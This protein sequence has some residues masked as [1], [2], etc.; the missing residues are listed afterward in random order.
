[1]HVCWNRRRVA[2]GSRRRGLGTGTGPD[3][4]LGRAE[5]RQ[6][7]GGRQR[8]AD[9]RGRRRGAGAGLGRRAA[10]GRARHPRPR[11]RRLHARLQCRGRPLQPRGGQARAQQP[12]G[13]ARGRPADADGRPERQRHTGHDQHADR[14]GR[15]HPLALRRRRQLGGDPR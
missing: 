10:G 12:A 2:A 1:A 11:G 5:G 13:S 7:P 3:D 6:R 8:T 14:P 15:R 9:S 4:R